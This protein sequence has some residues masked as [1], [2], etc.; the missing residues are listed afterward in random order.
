MDTENVKVKFI[1]EDHQYS[2][3]E[4]DSCVQELIN[5]KAEW[6]DQYMTFQNEDP[7]AKLVVEILS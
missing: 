4:W 5:N 1:I 6:T 2:T 7:Q 3:T